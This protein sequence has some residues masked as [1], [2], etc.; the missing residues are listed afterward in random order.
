MAQQKG[1]GLRPPAVITGDPS[2][3]AKVLLWDEMRIAPLLNPSNDGMVTGGTG[4]R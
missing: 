1:S 4:G 3:P 2:A